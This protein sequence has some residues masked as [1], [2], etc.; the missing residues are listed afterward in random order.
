MNAP[1]WLEIARAE[2][3]VCVHPHGSSHP[4]IG[5]YHEHA[6]ISGYDDKASW[7]SSFINWSLA[8]VGITGTGSALARSWLDWG[9]P[10]EEPIL[11]CVT[12]LWREDP[13]AHR[14]TRRKRGVRGNRRDLPSGEGAP[15]RRRCVAPAYS[16]PNRSQRRR[17]SGRRRSGAIARISSRSLY[18]RQS[19]PGACVTAH[20]SAPAPVDGALARF[21]SHASV[22]Q[23]LGLE[24]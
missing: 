3:G 24:T 16:I 12:V 17:V 6:G 1:P 2:I 21:R 19:S 9:Q 11:G 10:L 8:Q 5:E 4:R 14:R 13:V 15:W 20:C 7:C 23:L 18:V 22:A